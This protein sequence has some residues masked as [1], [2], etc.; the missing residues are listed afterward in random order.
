MNATG[1]ILG[2]PH[3]Y[4]CDH[5]L[6]LVTKVINDLPEFDV[7]LAKARKIVGSIKHSSSL[8]EQLLELQRF[9]KENAVSVIQDIVTRWWSTFNMVQ[10]LMRLRFHLEYLG[11]Q[12]QIKNSL[13]NEEWALLEIITTTLSPFMYFQKLL[14]GQKYVTISFMPGIIAL[15]RTQL[16][17]NAGTE[18]TYHAEDEMQNVA[19]LTMTQKLSRSLLGH[20]NIHFGDGTNVLTENLTR[21][22]ANRQKGIS[23]LIF[24][25]A[26]LDPRMKGLTP[27]VPLNEQPQL[28]LNILHRLICMHSTDSATIV[29]SL[30]PAVIRTSIDHP[31]AFKEFDVDDFYRQL[32]P[33]LV[34]EVDAVN[35]IEKE[36]EEELNRYK[37][38]PIQNAYFTD[39]YGIRQFNNPLD[40]WRQNESKYPN[41]ARLARRV[42]CIPATSAPSERIFSA[43]GLTIGKDRAS[44]IPENVDDLIFLHNIVDFIPE[45][46]EPAVIE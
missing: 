1:E 28:W 42:L 12:N 26:A 18:S 25:G 13:N 17:V 46:Y 8:N 35:G 36:L 27:S 2:K 32:Q 39:E 21:G 9:A 33:I 14:E 45:F 23:E 16:A 4:C 38:A 30:Q 10:R 5:V 11:N 15:I 6:E 3:H 40:W 37:N 29:P 22:F 20:F 24:F 43:A 31:V 41:V 44:L 19:D 34:V 7:L